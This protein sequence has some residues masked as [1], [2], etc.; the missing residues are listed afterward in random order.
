MELGSKKK[1]SETDYGIADF[2]IEVYLSDKK[3]WRPVDIE[4][5][6][7][8]EDPHELTPHL[9]Q[10][11]AFL[12]GIDSEGRVVD[13]SPKYNADWLNNLKS[14]RADAKYFDK[15]LSRYLPDEAEQ[16]EEQQ[17]VAELH[18][19]HGLP[20]VISQFKNHPKYA[21]SRHLLKFEAFYPREPPLLGYCRGEP[22]YP[23]EAVHTLRSKETWHRLARQVKEGELA[24]NVVK[25]RPKWNKK[26]EELMRDLPLE[27]FGEWQTEPYQPPVAENGI[28]PRNK[29][30]NVELFHPDMLPIG[31][32]HLKLPGLQRIAAELEI[33]CVPAVVGFDGVGRGCHP[34]IEGYV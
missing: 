26:T 11:V 34:V 2:F 30:G 23:R 12:I 9:E 29:F 1:A 32:V 17:E 4:G 28:V 10:P 16:V 3:R 31:T 6:S 25:A 24:Y 14:M 33:D 20:K 18:E 7:V 22:V 15:V 13:L 8:I 27:V 5:F 19:Q 21:L